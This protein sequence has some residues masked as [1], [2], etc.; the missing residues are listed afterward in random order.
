MYF[1][2]V[3]NYS[4]FYRDLRPKQDDKRILRNP[5]KGW[6]VHYIDNGIERPFYRDSIAEGDTLLDFPYLNHMYLRF[7]WGDIEKEEGVYDW[8]YIDAIFDKWGKLGYRFSLRLCTYEGR[9][10][11][12]CYPT[13]KWVFDKGAKCYTH[14]DIIEPVFDDPIYLEKLEIFMAE[15]ARKFDGH[16]LVEFVDVGTFGTWGEGHTGDGF[17]FQY[18]HATLLRHIEMTLRNFKKTYVLVN[19]DMLRHGK[20][21]YAGEKPE[22]MVEFCRMHGTGIRDDSIYVES[23]VKNYGYDTLAGPSV[24]DPFWRQAPVDIEFQHLRCQTPEIFREGYP[25]LASLQRSHATFACFHGIP[26]D[27]LK[28]ARNLTE[29]AGARLGYWYYPEGIILPEAV[30]G[31]TS[32]AEFTVSNRGFGLGYFK[33]DLEFVLKDEGGRLYHLG[34]TPAENIRWMPYEATTVRPTMDFTGVPAGNYQLSLALL[35]G[36]RPISFAAFENETD[37]DRLIIDNISVR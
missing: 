4:P 14:G 35:D 29:Y 30:S 15:Y 26:R 7:D 25:G 33:G 9:D 16:P 28:M 22:D 27:W 23:C 31:L 20:G 32:V 3:V 8:S 37:N 2:D 34:R 17:G 13:P 24:F 19:D 12:V 5:H 21:N 6:C 11:H 36:D 18:P 10:D 1:Y